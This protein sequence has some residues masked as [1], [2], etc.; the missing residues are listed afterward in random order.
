MRPES[1]TAAAQDPERGESVLALDGRGDFAAE[2]MG[3]E[4]EAVADPEDR[5]AE[6]EKLRGGRRRAF[7]IDAL[8]A[9]RKNDPLG[10]GGADLFDG[11]RGR[12]DFRINAQLADLAGDELGILRPEID[13]QDFIHGAIVSPA[14]GG[15]KSPTLVL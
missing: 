10:A 2:E 4:L 15:L 9:A 12:P 6:G 1:K 7:F 14:A 5:Q 11:G 8:R 13:H 3:H